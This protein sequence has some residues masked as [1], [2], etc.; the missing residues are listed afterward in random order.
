MFSEE[1]M[2]QARG[3]RSVQELRT[4]ANECGFEMSAESAE[5]YYAAL[6]PHG[7]EVAD[8]ELDNVTGGGCSGDDN[9][10]AALYSV[11]ETVMLASCKD[12]QL[13]CRKYCTVI[14]RE[15]KSNEWH[16]TV[17]FYGLTREYRESELCSC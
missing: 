16:Y 10:P 5:K 11:G 6:H 1:L 8:D 14:K 3:A 4:M 12:S 7:G 9:K 15:Y 2:K 13:I 17:D